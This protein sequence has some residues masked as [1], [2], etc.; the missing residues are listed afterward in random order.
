M[1][2]LN[3]LKDEK[4]MRIVALIA[5]SAAALAI[6]ACT[7]A[8]DE[9]APAEEAAAEAEVAQDAA[10]DAEADTAATANTADCPT[11]PDADSVLSLLPR[12]VATI[13][14]IVAATTHTIVDRVATYYVHNHR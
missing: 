8:A 10:A 6:T 7:P 5:A 14:A 9:A 3:L 13:T 2:S 4:H 1:T 11:L 12:V